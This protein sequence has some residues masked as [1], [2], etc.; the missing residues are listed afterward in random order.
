MS[1]ILKINIAE[2]AGTLRTLLSQQKTSQGKE[3]VQAIY[4]LKTKQVETVQHLAVLLGRDRRTVQR[5]LRQYRHGGLSALLSVKKSP[6]RPPS[7]P[8][9]VLERLKRELADEEGFKSYGEVRTWLH[10][11]CGIEA[12]YKVVHKTVRYR[13]KSKLKVPRPVSVKQPDGATEDF[14]KK[15][16]QLLKAIVEKFK[17]ISQLGQRVRYWCEDETRMGLHTL[18]GR[19][20]TLK[21]VKPRG[22]VQWKFKALWLYGLIEPRTGESFFYEFCHLDTICFEK[23]LELFAQAYPNDLHII[24]LDNGSCHQALDLTIPE[25]VILLFQPS[26]CPEVNP[27]ERLWAEIK[28]SLKWELFD[29]LDELRKAVQKIFQNLHQTSITSVTR[30]QFLVQAL[31]VAGI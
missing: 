14:K 29:N 30:W 2:S 22:Q 13:L 16:P 11:I 19:L 27:I 24:Q 31:C 1:G 10:A 28:K 7:I 8:P 4:W 12:D 3:R 18:G 17:D 21:G 26:H 9:E 6:G 25:N 15:L 5:W 20:L 23:F